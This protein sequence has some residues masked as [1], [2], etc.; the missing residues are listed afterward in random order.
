MNIGNI[1]CLLMP[2]HRHHVTYR[3]NIWIEHAKC[4]RCG[5]EY[6]IDHLTQV[7]LPLRDFQIV[8]EHEKHLRLS[9][10]G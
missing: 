6:G 2:W 1:W 7:R 10:L 8:Q 9:R 4:E 5:R 3:D